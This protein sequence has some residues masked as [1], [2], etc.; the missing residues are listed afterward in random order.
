MGL[1]YF[2]RLWSS[3]TMKVVRES[4][5]TDFIGQ[6]IKDEKSPTLAQLILFPRYNLKRHSAQ[7]Y[8]MGQN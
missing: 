4:I 5:L 7:K 6:T 8:I 1:Y 3:V 2:D